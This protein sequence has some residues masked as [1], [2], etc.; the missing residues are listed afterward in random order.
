[1][2]NKLFFN[3][4]GFTLIELLVVI[5]IIGILISMITVAFSTAQSSSRDARR[6][7]DLKAIQDAFEQYYSDTGATGAIRFSYDTCA[8][9]TTS[10]YFP[11]G[12]RPKDPKTNADYTCN[13]SANSY[14]VCALMEK[15][16]SGNSTV[17][18]CSS[19]AASGDYFCVSNLQ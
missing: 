6:R 15:D 11:T 1:M 18:N 8:N 10:A 3:Q 14:C 7:S 17:S 19:Y 5:G 4:K 9:M 2:K 16:D 12:S 13:A